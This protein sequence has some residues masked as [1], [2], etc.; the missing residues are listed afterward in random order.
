MRLIAPLLLVTIG[1]A[2]IGAAQDDAPADTTAELSGLIEQQNALADQYNAIIRTIKERE[3]IVALDDA[4]TAANTA[5]KKAEDADEGVAAARKNRAVVQVD[6]AAAVDKALADHAE[7]GEIREKIATIRDQMLDGQWQIAL[8]RFSL[9]HALS[10]VGRALASDQELADA[11]RAI[12]AASGQD[13]AAARTAFEKLR[14]EKIATL[15]AGQALLAQIDEATAAG[16]RLQQSLVA[17]EERLSPIRKEIEASQQQAID[18][19]QSALETALA[20]EPL[21]KL[22]LARNDAVMAY[23]KA[24]NEAVAADPQAGDL[25]KQ[26]EA[27]A[28]KVKELRPKR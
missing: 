3:A 22:R 6:A 11:K 2:C 27:I 14:G 17:L 12:N 20:A 19:A 4:I 15:E 28:A 25:K 10:P 9:E 8:A 1:L 24:V 23:N 16:D 26:Y 7:A 18:E 5:L 21:K 13:K